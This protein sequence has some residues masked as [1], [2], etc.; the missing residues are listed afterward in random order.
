MRARWRSRC[1][2]IG[3]NFRDVLN[4]LGMYPGRR[5]RSEQRVLGHGDGVGAGVS[6]V[7]WATRDGDGGWDRSG[8][9]VTTDARWC[10]EHTARC[11]RSRKRRAFRSF[12]DGV[13]WAARFGGVEAR[14]SGCLIHAAAGG[15]GMAAVQLAQCTSAR[16]CWGRRVRE[17]GDGEVAGRRRRCRALAIRVLWRRFGPGSGCR[18][19][20]LD[21]AISS[22]RACRCCLEGGRFMEMGKADFGTRRVSSGPI[23]G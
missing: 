4:A 12:F 11:C 21:G 14:V 17:M 22:T 16:R 2:R 1:K 9:F 20:R 8:S 5:V 6:G 3:L 13:V 7:S 10:L 18:A 15:V 23:P 19:Q